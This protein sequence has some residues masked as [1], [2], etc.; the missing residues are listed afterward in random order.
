[1]S[2]YYLKITSKYN[3]DNLTLIDILG[4]EFEGYYDGFGIDN[5][6]K[7]KDF[8]FYHVPEN[9]INLLPNKLS[10]YPYI[11]YESRIEQ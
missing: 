6:T 7:E 5:Q 4:Q 1:M 2:S 3:R 11:K 9:L 8:F 10:E